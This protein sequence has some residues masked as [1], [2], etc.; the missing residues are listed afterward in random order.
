MVILF[1]LCHANGY[2]RVGVKL[3]LRGQVA[4]PAAVQHV[5]VPTNIAPIENT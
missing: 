4:L 2:M 5:I 3:V 1:T